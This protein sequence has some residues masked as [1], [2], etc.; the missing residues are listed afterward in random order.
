M[1]RITLEELLARTRS[2]EVVGEVKMAR[3][4]EWGTISVPLK[5][6]SA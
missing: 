4:P 1:M 6:V 2:I 5:V 3:W